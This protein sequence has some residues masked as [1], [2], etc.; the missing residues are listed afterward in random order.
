MS[1]IHDREFFSLPAAWAIL[2]E[3]A[4]KYDREAFHLAAHMLGEEPADVIRGMA[5]VIFRLSCIPEEEGCYSHIQQ[6]LLATAGV[7]ALCVTLVEHQEESEAYKKYGWGMSHDYQS[8]RHQG[9]S[10]KH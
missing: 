5:Q 8:C 2:A 1:D 4:K 9:S 10:G 6:A 7:I 3:S